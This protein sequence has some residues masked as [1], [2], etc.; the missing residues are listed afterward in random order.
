MPS[1]GQLKGHWYCI[2]FHCTV[3]KIC[4]T[5][6]QEI[7]EPGK[8]E[9]GGRGPH[10]NYS[11]YDSWDVHTEVVFLKK[12]WFKTINTFPSISLE[13]IAFVRGFSQ[14]RNRVRLRVIRFG[15]ILMT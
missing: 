14:S 10:L 6:G 9:G 7:I 15:I 11:Q 13:Q 2:L 8:G 5:L 4:W 3:C 12:K 1:E